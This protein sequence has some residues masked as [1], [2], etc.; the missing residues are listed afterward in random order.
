MMLLA[1]DFGELKDAFLR[2]LAIVACATLLFSVVGAAYGSRR[3]AQ[4]SATNKLKL[5][6]MLWG[7]PSGVAIA[8]MVGLAFLS[9]PDALVGL[10]GSLALCPIIGGAM[11]YGIARAIASGN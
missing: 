9:A 7:C 3:G 11:S 2:L 8:A 10:M 4:L 1:G 5:T 6:A